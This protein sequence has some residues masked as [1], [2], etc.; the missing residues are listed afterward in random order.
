MP[1][2]PATTNLLTNPSAEVDNA[3]FV[4]Y[5]GPG[6][7]AVRSTEQA[8]VGSASFLVTVDLGDASP[9]LGWTSTASV[10]TD[11][12]TFVGRFAAKAGPTGTSVI[13]RLRVWVN[14]FGASYTSTELAF[15]L[16]STW[17]EYTLGP[18]SSQGG[19]T[20]DRIDITVFDDGDNVEFY[21]DA[22]MIEESSSISTYVDGSLGM[23]YAWTGT[24]HA[25][26]STRSTATEECEGTYDNFQL[27]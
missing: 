1:C 3:N 14:G 23:G 25:S 27:R 22:G 24:A 15:T 11:A 10:L 9:V 17:T 7:S 18:I 20:I 8:Y 12:H 5:T 21:M 6:S 19:D 2:Q 13:V 4:A 26:T 16:Q